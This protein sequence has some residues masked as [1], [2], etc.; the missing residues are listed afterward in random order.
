[1]ASAAVGRGARRRLLAALDAPDAAR[2]IANEHLRGLRALASLERL[3]VAATSVATAQAQLESFAGREAPG[4]DGAA[5]PRTGI[6]RTHG[7]RPRRLIAGP[8]HSQRHLLPGW[9]R[10]PRE[11]REAWLARERDTELAAT[12][13]D[14]AGFAWVGT[15]SVGEIAELV[16]LETGRRDPEFV[17]AFFELG[18]RLGV[19]TWADGGIR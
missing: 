5:G 7:A 15:R 11:A 19:A 18:V 8:L 4:R 10:L 1:V 2:A 12:I 3:G 13:A 16:W 6:A 17:A 14:L 9:R